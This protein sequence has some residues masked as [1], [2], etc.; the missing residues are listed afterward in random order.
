VTPRS[1]PAAELL[2]EFSLYPVDQGSH[3]S[4]YVARSLDIVDRSGLPYHLHAMGTVL[5]GDWDSCFHVIRQC[6]RRMKKDCG[7]VELVLK[8]D[9]RAGRRGALKGKV[10]SVEKKLGRR[11]GRE[12]G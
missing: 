11:L 12:R 2:V 6:F 5:E 8:A 4:P 10:R 9:Y 1:H 7:R 3:L